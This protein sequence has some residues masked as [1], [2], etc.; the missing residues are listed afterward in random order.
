MYS[1]KDII[2]ARRNQKTRETRE[3]ELASLSTVWGG[4]IS[5]LYVQ[6]KSAVLNS[7]ETNISAELVIP[8]EELTQAEVETL[9][10]FISAHRE[11]DLF[12]VYEMRAWPSLSEWSDSIRILNEIIE[13][14]GMEFD[15]WTK[16]KLVGKT[17]VLVSVKLNLSV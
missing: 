13:H 16:R 8:A 3:R 2:A 14:E 17:P 6:I 7:D 10:Y 1:F 15:I 9:G 5:T 11:N 12:Q 4:R